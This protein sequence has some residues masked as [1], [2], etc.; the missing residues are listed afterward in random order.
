MEHV[1][2]IGE[3]RHAIL[4]GRKQKIPCART[5]YRW[6]GNIQLDHRNCVTLWTAFISFRISARD[7]HLLT[8]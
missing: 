6:D 2:R 4:V 7:V 3:K 5:N 1:V 8:W